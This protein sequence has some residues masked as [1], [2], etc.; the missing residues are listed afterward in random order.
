MAHRTFVSIRVRRNDNEDHFFLKDDK[1]ELSFF[2]SGN[3]A[4]N[5]SY[6]YADLKRDFCNKFGVEPDRFTRFYVQLLDTDLSD[7]FEESSAAIV[8]LRVDEEFFQQKTKIT[9]Q[10]EWLNADLLQDSRDRF[11]E[12]DLP[13][14]NRLLE[15]V[16]PIELPAD[17]IEGIRVLQMAQ[18]LQKLVIFAG[19]GISIDSNIPLWS[20]IKQEMQSVLGSTVSPETDS[21]LMAQ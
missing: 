10:F 20:Q 4:I 6:R 13:V 5:G 15:S 11:N 2:T 16:K 8:E 1:G 3:I 14:F 19:A 18:S 7:I 9:E 17:L 12:F 21:I